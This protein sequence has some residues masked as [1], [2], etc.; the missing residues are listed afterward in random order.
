MNAKL[1][2]AYRILRDAIVLNNIPNCDLAEIEAEILGADEE[3]LRDEYL[4]ETR[5]TQLMAT[6]A[7]DVTSICEALAV[8]RVSAM[9]IST[10]F[11]NLADVIETVLVAD[12]D[13]CSGPTNLE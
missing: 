9:N 5:L 1:S 10:L 12:H 3:V 4:F 8:L 11:G 2:D 7:R 6:S 13:R